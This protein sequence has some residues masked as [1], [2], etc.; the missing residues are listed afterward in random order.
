MVRNAAPKARIP[1]YYL[2]LKSDSAGKGGL[3]DRPKGRSIHTFVLGPR[4]LV[5]ETVRVHSGSRMTGRILHTP[6]DPLL[7]SS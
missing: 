7:C 1:Y 4:C 5:H 6:G 3:S 2:V